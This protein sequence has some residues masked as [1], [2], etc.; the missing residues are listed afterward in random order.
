MAVS[1]SDFTEGLPPKPKIGFLR[2]CIILAPDLEAALPG[3][4]SQG[5]T[6]YEKESDVLTDRD[7]FFFVRVPSLATRLREHVEA[8]FPQ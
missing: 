5:Y 4:H 8:F 3:L 2:G 1:L 6:H 7:L